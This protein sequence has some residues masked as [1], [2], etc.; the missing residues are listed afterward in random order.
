MAVTAVV[1]S[2][3]L[4]S[5]IGIKGGAM[6]STVALALGIA[7]IGLWLLLTKRVTLPY[8]SIIK[9]LLAVGVMYLLVQKVD[10][11]QPL[12]SLLLKIGVGALSYIAVMLLLFRADVAVFIRQRQS[13]V[14]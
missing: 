2:Y 5:A 8:L 12:T 3:F 11:A 13:G 1:L 10:A 7:I 6:A 4:V 14:G 9:M